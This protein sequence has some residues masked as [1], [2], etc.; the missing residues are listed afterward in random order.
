LHDRYDICKIANLGH[1]ITN[2]LENMMKRY[3]AAVA[4]DRKIPIVNTIE[5]M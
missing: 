1:F 2:G 4:Y 5:E 3:I